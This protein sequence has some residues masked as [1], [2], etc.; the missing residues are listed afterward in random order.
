LDFSGDKGTGSGGLGARSGGRHT[1]PL[2]EKKLL[3]FE[4]GRVDL[5]GHFGRCPKPFQRGAQRWRKQKKSQL[6][7]IQGQYFLCWNPKG[8][9]R[10]EPL[11]LREANERKKGKGKTTPTRDPVLEQIED[12]KRGP[13][14]GSPRPD[15]EAGLSLTGRKDKGGIKGRGVGGCLRRFFQPPPQIVINHVLY[16]LFSRAPG[17]W[18]R[19]TRANGVSS[20]ERELPNAGSI[21]Q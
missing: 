18:P 4:G 11:F 19:D 9:F 1:S 8:P 6:S 16:I 3:L 21:I 5:M 10:C 15:D 14:A 20:T 7:Q 12:T 17:G 2:L 13:L